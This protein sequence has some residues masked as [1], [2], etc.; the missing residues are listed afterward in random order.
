MEQ[1]PRSPMLKFGPYVVD[2]AAGEV[3]KNGSRIRLQEKPLRVL[4]LLAER[5]GQLVTREDLKKHLWPEDTF[6]DFETGLN[7]AVSR[8]RDALSDSAEKPR[9]IETIPR[10]GYR[11]ISSVEFVNG[12]QPLAN[13]SGNGQKLEPV[14]APAPITQTLD[15]LADAGRQLDEMR[16]SSAAWLRGTVVASVL[17]LLGTIWWLTPLPDPRI[18]DI[19][20]VTQ[21]GRQDFLVRPATD[22]IRI[23]YVQ[24]SGDHY[25]LM[26]SSTNGGEAQKLDAPFPNT[27][28]WDVSPEGSKYLITSFRRRGEPAPLWTWPATGGAP[29]KIGDIVSG[30]ASYSPDGK[31]IVYHAGH[32]LLVANAD[33]TGVRKLANLGREEPDSPVWSPDGRSIRFNRNDPER[34]TE[35]IWEIGVDGN[36]PHPVLPNW[37]ETPKQCCGTWTPD[38]RYFLFVEIVNPSNRLYAIREKGVWWRRSPRGPFLVAAE[39]TGSWSPLVSRDGKYIYFYGKSV[40]SD[41]ETVDPATGQFS[42]VLNDTRPRMLSVSPDGQ[43]VSYIQSLSG[44]IWVSHLDGSAARRIPLPGLEGAFPRLSP[45]NQKIILTGIKSGMPHNVY[46]VSSAGGT[47]QPVVADTTGM[48]DPDWSPDGTR[49]VV[50]RML[51]FPSSKPQS[52]VLAFLDLNTSRI[53][54]VPGSEDLHQP[55]WSP[56]GHYLAAIRGAEAELMVFDIASQVWSKLAEGRSM[57]FPVWSP[58]SASV[59]SQDILAPGEPLYLVEISSGR[60][61]VVVSFEKALNTGIQRCVFVAVAPNGAPM[62]AFDR[63]NSDIFGARLLLP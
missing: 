18:T 42:T 63:N 9:Y 36:N 31:Q 28:V 43:W 12:H 51:Q 45:D 23:F 10:R 52:T 57:S 60:R 22:G 54:N 14:F 33:G 48:S 39:P 53:T 15:S 2:L 27:L 34:D 11:F 46:V 32:D 50:E 56:N 1:A 38:G 59:Y 37:Q 35:S 58:D 16:T 8:L 4:A 17:I 29:V 19:F 61:S 44:M 40:H 13:T 21:T 24:R 55:R 26:Q 30:S 25:D 3:R 20:A 41:L 7:T 5:Q 62:I 49:L 47:P 6:V